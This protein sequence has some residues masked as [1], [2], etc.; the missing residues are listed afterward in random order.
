MSYW[1]ES[2][3]FVLLSG[4]SGAKSSIST[5]R[6]LTMNPALTSRRRSLLLSKIRC[7]GPHMDKRRPKFLPN[8]RILKKPN[9]GIT[10]WSGS[11]PRRSDLAVAKN[12]LSHEEINVLNRI[13]TS[14]LE[15]AELQ[16][17]NRKPMYMKDWV[18]KLDDF[19]R[20]SE[21]EIL[22]HA[23]KISHESAIKKAEQEYSRFRAKQDLLP[24]PVDKD[25]DLVSRQLEKMKKTSPSES[26]PKRRKKK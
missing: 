23:G 6:A 14:Y 20:L 7:I 26:N 10:S 13:V 24:R 5:R 18:T 19:L 2:V 16:A 11:Q 1:L 8:E 12:F 25:F 9:I 15:F 17:L 3:T 4:F 21:R 22:N